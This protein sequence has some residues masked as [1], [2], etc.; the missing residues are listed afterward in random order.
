MVRDSANYVCDDPESIINKANRAPGVSRA[1]VARCH[2]IPVA[3]IDANERRGCMGSTADHTDCYSV[4]LEG[5]AQFAPF[6][7]ST[8]A[9]RRVRTGSADAD[10]AGEPV[11]LPI[12]RA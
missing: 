6:G 5:G 12:R 10:G 3:S 9:N 11:Y 7:S 2:Y 1:I 8:A 4:M